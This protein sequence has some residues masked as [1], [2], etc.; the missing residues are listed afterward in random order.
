VQV[1][2]QKVGWPLSETAKRASSL[3]GGGGPRAAIPPT[4]TDES[5]RIG[6]P[7]TPQVPPQL[8][9]GAAPLPA[10]AATPAVPVYQPPPAHQPLPVYSSQ[11]Y[12]APQPAAPLPHGPLPPV[13]PPASPSPPQHG[14]ARFSSV[15]TRRR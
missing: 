11:P 1:A 4:V 9:P 6:R 2:A 8:T 7:E 13:P 5:G 10:Y 14:A 15:F 3:A 12:A